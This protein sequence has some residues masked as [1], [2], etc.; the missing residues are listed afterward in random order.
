MA[1]EDHKRFSGWKRGTVYINICEW[2]LFEPDVKFSIAC[3]SNASIYPVIGRVSQD[4]CP[5]WCLFSLWH[6]SEVTATHKCN[7][8][9]KVLFFWTVVKGRQQT[10]VCGCLRSWKGKGNT[11]FYLD[12][13]IAILVK[14]FC[15]E[16]PY[17][18]LPSQLQFLRAGKIRELWAGINWIIET[19][20]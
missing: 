5:G 2:L 11:S 14:Q 18:L 9:E 1:E 4:L 10:I 20:N 15:K 16:I 19:G 12:H 7:N 17:L 3:S 6:P 8:S 13:L